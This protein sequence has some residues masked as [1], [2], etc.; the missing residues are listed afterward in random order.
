M[1]RRRDRSRTRQ[2]GL[3][4]PPQPSGR[5]RG[6]RRRSAGFRPDRSPA[7]PS[8]HHCSR[9]GEPGHLGRRPIEQLA[10]DEARR[11]VPRPDGRARLRGVRVA[12]RA[13]SSSTRSPASRR[14]ELPPSA[15][16]VSTRAEQ[17]GLAIELVALDARRVAGRDEA[18]RYIEALGSRRSRTTCSSFAGCVPARTQRHLARHRQ[19]PAVARISRSSASRRQARRTIRSRSGSFRD[20]RIFASIGSQDDESAPDRG[21]GWMCRLVDAGVLTA[22]DRAASQVRARPR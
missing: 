15:G 4:A 8:V 17:T 13:T 12:A 7:R 11:A 2:L 21:H 20:G 19:D 5:T 6:A 1:T 10:Q 16:R 9:T 3:P 14:D 22:V 18:V